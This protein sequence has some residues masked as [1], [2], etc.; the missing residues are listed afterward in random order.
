KHRQLFEEKKSLLFDF[1]PTLQ[2]LWNNQYEEHLCSRVSLISED[3]VKEIIPQEIRAAHKKIYIALR[4]PSPEITFSTNTFTRLFDPR[5]FKI[6]IQSFLK[7]GV[8]L[9]IL[10]GDPKLFLEKSHPIML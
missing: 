9:H 5:T 3:L 6:G 7:R 8:R 4:D 10:I 2:K 1:L